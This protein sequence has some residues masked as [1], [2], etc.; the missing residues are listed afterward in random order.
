MGAF[1][2]YPNKQVT[3]GEGGMIVSDHDKWAGMMRALRNQGRNSGDQWLE[4]TY[5]GYNYRMDELSAALGRVQMERLDELMRKRSTVAEMYADRLAAVPEIEIPAVI[6]S[7]TQISWFVYVV[8][9]APGVSR[10]AVIDA[11]ASQG[12]PSRPYFA[13]IHFQPFYAQR[14]GY[15]PGMYPVTEDLGKRSLALPFSGV[16]GEGEIERVCTALIS[17]V[18]NPS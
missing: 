17:A 12:I 8:R 10:E 7:T 2:F 6:P 1:G 3:T 13:P 9:L 15:R 4:H 16:M 5:L 18:G 14:F 11:L